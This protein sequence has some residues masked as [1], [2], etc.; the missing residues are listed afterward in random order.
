MT[1]LSSHIFPS[2]YYSTRMSQGKAISETQVNPR[3]RCGVRGVEILRSKG[4]KGIISECLIGKPRACLDRSK[5][6]GGCLHG[7]T[8]HRH[9][10]SFPSRF[11]TT[12][13]LSTDFFTS[14]F[15]PWDLAVALPAVWGFTTYTLTCGQAAISCKTVKGWYKGLYLQTNKNK[16]RKKGKR[17]GKKSRVYSTQ[18]NKFRS[19]RILQGEGDDHFSFTSVVYPC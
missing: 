19:L 18:E 17:K 4:V 9:P 10:R 3:Q 2:P 7:T 1:Q 16:K 11:F 12:F 14:A 5:H 15:S 6:Q 8:Y 13:S